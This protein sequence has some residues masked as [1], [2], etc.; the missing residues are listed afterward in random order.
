[1]KTLEQIELYRETGQIAAKVLTHL[2]D[3]VRPGI[4]TY[5]IAKIAEDLIVNQFEAIPSSIGQYGFQ[6]ALNSSVNHVVCHGVPSQSEILKAGDI[7]NLD[8]TVKKHGLI[9]DTSR[10]YLVGEVNEHAKKL[11]LV[12][13]EC[14]WKGIEVVKPGARVGDIGQVISAH[15][16][17]HGYTIVREYCGHGIGAQMHQEPQIPHFGYKGQGEILKPGMTF[18]IEP[19]VNQ[20]SR[21]VRHLSD[22]WT[23]V[24]KDGKLSA[25][26]EHTILVTESGFEVLTL[27]EEEKRQFDRWFC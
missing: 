7:V 26:W 13:Y 1:M 22:D 24:T 21:Q 18:T 5:S 9:A 27:R 12:T 11:C 17:R 14:L 15:A 6:F 8:V 19:M 4:D 20:G 10:M 25:Q 2:K 23:V 16:K 3:I